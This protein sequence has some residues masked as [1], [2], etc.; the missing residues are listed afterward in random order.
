MEEI[1][2]FLRVF[3][4]ILIV[5]AMIEFGALVGIMLFGDGL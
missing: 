1:D 4:T 2:K 3:D 5:L